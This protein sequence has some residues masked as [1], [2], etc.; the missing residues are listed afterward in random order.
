MSKLIY[1]KEIY[2][3]N[4]DD[5][6]V[7]VVRKDNEVIGLNYMQGDVD[8]DFDYF[9]DNYDCIDKG[10]TRFYNSI[11]SALNGT[12]EIDRINQAIWAHF[13]YENN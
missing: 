1:S 11:K 7:L 8:D 6:Y 4:E 2:Q 13:A 5:R 9:K 10:L 3:C 12:T